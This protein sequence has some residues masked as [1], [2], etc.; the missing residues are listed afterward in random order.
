MSND[1]TRTRRK[2]A[3][4]GKLTAASNRI[5]HGARAFQALS[6][7]A[8]RPVPLKPTTPLINRWRSTG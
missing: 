1:D 6:S 7:S 2:V 5:G 8:Q 3:V 4:E